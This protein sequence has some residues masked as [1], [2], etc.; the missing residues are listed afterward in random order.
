MSV[1]HSNLN[2]KVAST[3]GGITVGEDGY[4]HQAVEDV[5]LS[6]A[7]PNVTVVVPADA[8]ETKAV[9]EAADEAV[10]VGREAGQRAK[11]AAAGRSRRVDPSV[12]SP[13]HPGDT[14]ERRP[15]LPMTGCSA[16]DLGITSS[17]E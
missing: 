11:R 2:V 1:A 7:L 14:R 4:S 5:A 8:I 9:V 6:L 3:H 16:A 13:V 12:D 15:E 17:S 10:T